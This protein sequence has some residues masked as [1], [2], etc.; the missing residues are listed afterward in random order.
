[1]MFAPPAPRVVTDADRVQ[2]NI[3][4]TVGWQQQWYRDAQ[5]RL[6]AVTAMRQLKDAA[7]SPLFD[8]DEADDEQGFPIGTPPTEDF[9]PAVFGVAVP[10]L[11][12]LKKAQAFEGLD[13]FG[14]VVAALYVEGPPPA[15]P[16]YQA[17]RLTGQGVYCVY[18]RHESG[19]PEKVKWRAYVMLSPG[20]TCTRPN[21]VAD[22]LSVQFNRVPGFPKDNEYP[23][24]VRFGV[25]N[26]LPV[27]IVRCGDAECYVGPTT[28]FPPPQ[29]SNGA[30][31]PPPDHKKKHVRLWHDAQRLAVEDAGNVLHPAIPAII[32]PLPDIE[33]YHETVEFSDTFRA[34]A[35]VRLAGNPGNSKY[36]TGQNNLGMQLQ[37]GLNLLWIAYDTHRSTWMAQLQHYDASF[38]PSGPPTPAKVMWTHHKPMSGIARFAWMSNDDSLW[39]SCDQGC[40]RVSAFALQ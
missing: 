15:A 27:I 19:A 34:M 11:F 14:P 28:G 10:T 7:G 5:R 9:G 22:S 31:S 20:T 17:L 4:P 6:N 25:D 21:S 29:P 30:N 23:P 38:N 33:K 13:P 12:N 2:D 3:T 36:G 16:S 8:V 40:C 24:V 39:V 37:N 18:L 32:E 1:M 26:G 35:W